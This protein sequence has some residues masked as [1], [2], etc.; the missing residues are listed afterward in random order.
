M[1]EIGEFRIAARSP[2]ERWQRV[3]ANHH[4]A[5]QPHENDARERD[6]ELFRRP[7]ERDLAIGGV[8]PVLVLQR[9]DKP[10]LDMI[11]LEPNQDL[12]KIAELAERHCV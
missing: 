1:R 5:G 6:P 4:D 9:L 8:V 3:C 7:V 11:I 10:R 2:L 12:S